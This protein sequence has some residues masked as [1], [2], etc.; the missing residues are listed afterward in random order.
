LFCRVERFRP[1]LHIVRMYAVDIVTFG[2]A[3][4]ARNRKFRVQFKMRLVA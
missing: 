4:G 1:G 3:I 2:N